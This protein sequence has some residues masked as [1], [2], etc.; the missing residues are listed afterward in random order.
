MGPAGVP[1]GMDEEG[2]PQITQIYADEERAGAMLTRRGVGRNSR[3]ILTPGEHA[4]PT[5]DAGMLTRLAS[6][7]QESFEMK[8]GY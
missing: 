8:S 1:T 7:K 2:D 6:F 5:C 4:A 3:W